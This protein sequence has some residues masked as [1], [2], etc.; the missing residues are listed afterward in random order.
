MAPFNSASVSA[1]LK[2]LYKFVIIIIIIIII[3]LAHPVG[4]VGNSIMCFWTDNFCLQQ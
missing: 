1:D 3:N 4:E 2:A